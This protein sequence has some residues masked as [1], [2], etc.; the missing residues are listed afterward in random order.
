VSPKGDA[1]GFVEIVRAADGAGVALL[2]PDRPG[3]NLVFGLQVR[4]CH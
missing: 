3:N 1:P 4:G 2:V